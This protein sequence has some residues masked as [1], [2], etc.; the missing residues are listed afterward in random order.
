MDAVRGTARDYT[1]GSIGRAILLLAVPMMLEMVMES[2]FAVVD[3]YFV[4]SL[5][6]SAVATVGL[7]ESVMT[8]MYAVA[9]GFAMGTTALVAR[10]IGEKDPEAAAN[11]AVQAIALAVAA[12][13]PFMLIGLF[14][15][16]DILAL[17]GAD[18]WSLEHGYRYTQWMMGSNVVIM[19]L[20]VI[21]AIFRGAGD[22]AIAMRVL[23]IA[24]GINIVLDPALIFGW[25]PLPE[26][27]I[28]G[29]AVATTIGRGIGVA[30]QLWVLL[31]GA[32]H[33]RVLTTQI[34][35]QG[36]VMMQLARTSAGGIG[37]LIIATSSWIGL[38]R[39][40]SEF[41][42]EALAGYTIAVRVFLFTLLPSW[43]LANA[44]AT[45]VGQNLGAGQ[46]ER[47][48]R[49][50]WITG[51]ANMAFLAVVSLVYIVLD[52]Q[53]MRLFTDEV[54]VV[55]PGADALRIMAYGYVIFSWGMVMPQAF[56]GAG[57]TLTPT[58]I[59]FLCF[60]LLE[61]PLAYLL[62]LR[63]GVGANG[64]Y[65]SIVV[66]ETAAALLAI[67]LFRRGTWKL[68]QV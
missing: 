63:W 66:A 46:P 64:V 24:N 1:Q 8:L 31:R 33:I 17:M 52:E 56:N 29:A 11:A 44:A 2:V 22:A 41:G 19:L 32:K 48:E 45:L 40:V 55:E 3:V 43:G 28:T 62:A 53:L 27:G 49:S 9:I 60:W 65:W 51:W 18:A 68:T 54:A 10:R 35:I 13:I 61:I 21:N 5:G 16:R 39:I 6:A 57:D 7:T 25:G 26:L 47:A 4:S 36:A 38:V 20:F 15:A 59:N 23:W 12:S 42:S 50:V 30:T 37:Q 34:R 14:F 58:K 67:A